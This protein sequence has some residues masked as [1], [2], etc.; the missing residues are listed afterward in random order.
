MAFRAGCFGLN[1]ATLSAL[2]DRNILFDSSYNLSYLYGP[3]F[4][5]PTKAFNDLTKLNGVWELPITNYHE[6]RLRGRH[7]LRHLDVCGM[8]SLEIRRILQVALENGPKHITFL[9]HSFSFL[10]NRDVQ[11]R[12]VKPNTIVIKRFQRLCEFLANNK[13]DYHTV[14]FSDLA[15]DL[16]SLCEGVHH[17]PFVG[18][19]ASLS[20]YLLRDIV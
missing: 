19:L 20:R 8:S 5:D 10:R 3:D 1:L 11:Y 16:T 7:R 13:K 4:A 9:L 18:N 6:F 14:T 15:K 2:R 12:K 17:I